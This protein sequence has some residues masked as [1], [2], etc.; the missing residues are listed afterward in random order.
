MDDLYRDLPIKDGK[1][2]YVEFSRML[3]HGTKEKDEEQ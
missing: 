2:D 1:L 3:K